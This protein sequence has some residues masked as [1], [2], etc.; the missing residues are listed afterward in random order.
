[1]MDRQLT[2]LLTSHAHHLCW[3]LQSDQ[4]VL[5]RIFSCIYLTPLSLQLSFNP[6]LQTFDWISPARTFLWI[7]DDI[8][9]TALCESGFNLCHRVWFLSHETT[10]FRALLFRNQRRVNKTCLSVGSGLIPSLNRNV[11]PVLCI[12]SPLNALGFPEQSLIAS[13]KNGLVILNHLFSIIAE[14]EGTHSL[15]VLQS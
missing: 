1:M 10:R 2:Y 15:L 13:Q 3:W 12:Q 11:L 14:D 6:W 8:S 9:D 5:C 4:H 7:V